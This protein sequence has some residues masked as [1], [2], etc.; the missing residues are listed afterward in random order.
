[1]KKRL[2][3]PLLKNIALH[4]IEDFCQNLVN[5]T[6]F[7]SQTKNLIKHRKKSK[8]FGFVRYVD[9][10]I[11]MHSKLSII[12]LLKKKLSHFLQY[13]GLDFNFADFFI[14]HTLEIKEKNRFYF[15]NLNIN[16]GFNFLGFFIRQY[17]TS[18]LKFFNYRSLK[19]RTLII[20]SKEKYSL[21]QIKL[22]NIILKQSNN[23]S[24]YF[25]IKKLNSIIY[26]W[27][28][29]YGK[30]DVNKI[31]LLQKI[32]FI[33][34]L[35]LKRRSKRIYKTSNKRA[36][37]FKK[38][39]NKWIFSSDTITLIKH[40]DFLFPLNK[41]TQVQKIFTPFDKN[42]IYWVQRNV[43]NYNFDINILI[44]LNLQKNTCTWCNIHFKFDDILKID[45]ILSQIKGGTNTPINF[46]VLHKY[47]FVNKNKLIFFPRSCVMGNYHA[48]F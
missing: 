8:I 17:K 11:V 23:I 5:N 46:Q 37:L 28:S 20:P 2:L 24:Q 21:Y 15:L 31:R 30:S 44:I 47:C 34:S 42:Q 38:I 12:L 19:F 39:G 7:T 29:Y 25:L 43:F 35:Q 33:L 27:S 26:T 14:T 48:Q 22:H 13:I 4:G 10:F 6:H 18:L 40:T 1:M 3:S 16:P 32:D 41:Y 45:F 36:S 9:I